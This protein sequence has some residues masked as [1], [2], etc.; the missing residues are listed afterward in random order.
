MKQRKQKFD[1]NYRQAVDGKYD[2][3]RCLRIKYVQSFI[4]KSV[5]GQ[6]PMTHLG[7]SCS[8]QAFKY[9]G[10]KEHKQKMEEI[11][12][13]I[14]LS[15]SSP[16]SWQSVSVHRHRNLHKNMQIGGLMLT[17]VEK[18]I[19]N[20]GQQ[21]LLAHSADSRLCQLGGDISHGEKFA[22]YKH[23][24]GY[25]FD[26]EHKICTSRHSGRLKKMFQ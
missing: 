7:S 22:C 24:W 20:N 12:L 11:T 2:F 4:F 25:L 14:L 9:K 10:G 6:Q 18:S 1:H 19:H 15:R 8:G 21:D 26:I 3:Q 23:L 5:L 16:K 17:L 13:H